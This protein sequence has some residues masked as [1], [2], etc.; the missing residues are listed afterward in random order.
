VIKILVTATVSIVTAII[1][2]YATI[3]VAEITRRDAGS[4][5]ERF[6]I[7]KAIAAEGDGV[8]GSSYGVLGPAAEEFV[9]KQD[10]VL[11]MVANAVADGGGT[12]RSYLNLGLSI[13][14]SSCGQSQSYVPVNWDISHRVNVGCVLPVTARR[15]IRLVIEPR[16]EG[17]RGQIQVSG[18]YAFI[19]SAAGRT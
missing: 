7:P 12:F 3:R 4:T 1:T 15:A 5:E 6:Q 11:I 13:N 10:G 16:G 14:G 2:A 17:L 9:P 18:S 19:P 8:D